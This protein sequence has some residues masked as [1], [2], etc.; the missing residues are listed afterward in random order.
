MT[1]FPA[2][3]E[4]RQILLNPG[5]VNVHDDVHAALASPDRC[6]REP[7][8]LRLLSRIRRKVTRVCGGDERHS[9]VLLGG[10]GTSA[11]EATIS[12]VIPPDGRVLIIGNGHYGER[13]RQIAAVHR[14]P[15]RYLD[16]GHGTPF[17]L[18]AVDEALAG[19][20]S[21]THV[22]AVHHETSTGMLNPLRELGDLTARHGRSLIVDAVSSLGAEPLDLDADHVDWCV[23]TANKCLEGYPGLSFAVASR[24]RLAAL[25]TVPPRTF[26]LDLHR[27]HTAQEHVGTS[28]FT[29]PVQVMAAFDTALDLMLQEGVHSRGARYA[30]LS[31]RVRTGLA[32]R[33]LSLR[34]PPDQ[35]SSSL[36]AFRLPDGLTYEALHDGLKAEGY[37]VY[38]GQS[39]GEREFRVATMGRLTEDDITGFLAAYDKVTAAQ[40][41]RREASPWE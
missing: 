2:S 19:D 32:D 26:S 36:T 35:R 11:L 12:S 34:L 5:P 4:S 21:L 22:A 24:E 23:G 15:H 17:A 25:E 7:E 30:T 6:H 20:P 8:A 18:R 16:F 3:P 28:L 37:V 29:L 9:A 31:E 10:S 33:G 13:L 1:P 38:A 27:H 41:H 39:P 40:P 14:I